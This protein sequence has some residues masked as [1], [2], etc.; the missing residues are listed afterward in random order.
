[1]RESEKNHFRSEILFEKYF[2]LSGLKAT[3]LESGRQIRKNR[4]ESR[5]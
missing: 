1:M 4:M 2:S 5:K 3:S